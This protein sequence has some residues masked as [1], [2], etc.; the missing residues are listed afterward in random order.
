MTYIEDIRKYK[1]RIEQEESDKKVILN[2]IDKYKKNILFRENKIA[3]ITSS[4]LILNK[5]LNKVLMIHHNIYKTWAWTG[6]HADGDSNL[7]DVAI[8][9]AKEETGLKNVTS[10]SG[11]IASIDILPVYGHIKRNSYVSAHLHLNIS[12]ILLADEKEELVINKEETSG[13]K[14]I[15]VSKI[16]DYSDE[17]YLINI[18]NKI[19]KKAA[20]LI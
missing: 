5:N 3:H 6:G 4:G 11:D 12:Y 15:D 10:M 2:Y 20:E 14:W 17:P 1:P 13:V 8:K 18:Y 19:I 16:L 9:E 7:L